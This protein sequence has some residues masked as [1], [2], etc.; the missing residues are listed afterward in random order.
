MPS[1]PPPGL[2]DPHWLLPFFCCLWLLICAG[3]SLG[4]GWF[5]LSREFRS[6]DEAA[7]Q[8]FRFRSGALGRWPFPVT[9]YGSCLF[10]TVNDQG[11]RLS[12]F[13][14]W[15]PFAPPLFIPWTAVQSVKAQRLLFV[16]YTL[17]RLKRGWPVVAIRGDAGKYLAA[18]YSRVSPAP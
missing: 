1:P 9:G 11:F 2:I 13:F 14:L 10:L 12:I 6:D 5:S 18:T 7:G 4:G 16:R 15:R 8:H 17:I 3:L